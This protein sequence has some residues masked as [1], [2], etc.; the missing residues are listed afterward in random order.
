VLNLT[1]LRHGRTQADDEDRYESRYDAELTDVGRSQA[2]RLLDDWK[3]QADR[4]FDVV[5]SSPLKRALETARMFSHHYAVPLVVNELLSELDAGKLSGMKRSEG[6]ERYPLPE[7][8]GPYDRI[9]KGSGE[10]EAQLQSRALL[11]IEAIV[12]MENQRYLIV[13]HGMILNAVVRSMLGIPLPVNGSSARF[14]FGDLG[15]MDLTYDKRSH[16]WTMLGFHAA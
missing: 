14:R 16:Q 8:I 13:A 6:L 9:V 7:F 12:N 4:R 2:Q 11:A 15:Y 5:V 1:L 10:S 3:R